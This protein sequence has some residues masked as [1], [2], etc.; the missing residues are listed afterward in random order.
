M[1]GKIIK[2]MLLSFGLVSAHKSIYLR[3]NKPIDQYKDTHSNNKSH[4]TLHIINTSIR[5]NRIDNTYEVNHS[6]DL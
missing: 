6:S 3:N 4:Y 2:C 1:F 5:R